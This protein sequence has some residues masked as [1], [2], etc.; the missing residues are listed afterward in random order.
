MLHTM[1]ELHKMQQEE[2][3]LDSCLSCL[4]AAY[5]SMVHD[6]THFTANHLIVEVWTPIDIMFGTDTVG[7]YPPEGM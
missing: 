2:E 1:P 7:P 6:N 5:W 3:N 4:G